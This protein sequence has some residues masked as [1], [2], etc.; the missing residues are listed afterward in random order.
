[1]ANRFNSEDLRVKINNDKKRL[2]L[3]PGQK[4]TYIG[5]DTSLIGNIGV[6]IHRWTDQYHFD[7]YFPSTGK[8]SSFTCRKVPGNCLLEIKDSA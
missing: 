3:L 4:C 2:G 1:M 6:I 5:T 8:Q 7:I